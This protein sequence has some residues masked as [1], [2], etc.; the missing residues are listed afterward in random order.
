M[1]TTPETTTITKRLCKWCQRNGDMAP[2]EAQRLGVC[3]PCLDGAAGWIHAHPTADRALYRALQA[4][5]LHTKRALYLDT[6]LFVEQP[7][8]VVLGY[9]FESGPTE[10][11]HGHHDLPTPGEF[12]TRDEDRSLFP[13]V[14]LRWMFRPHR[15]LHGCGTDAERIG[16]E[17]PPIDFKGIVLRAHLYGA[18]L[19][20]RLR[21]VA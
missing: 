3:L 2:P 4:G 5:L 8:A 16:K 13:D 21:D 9:H 6:R 18:Q 11:L 15:H 7:V 12:A 10:R 1:S 14:E 17:C 19:I 20:R